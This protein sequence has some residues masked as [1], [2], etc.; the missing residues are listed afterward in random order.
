MA[1]LKQR[2]RKMKNDEIKKEETKKKWYVEVYD[3]DLEE[4]VEVDE[5]LPCQSKEDAMSEAKE[6]IK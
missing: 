6:R 4:Y 3:E 1:V 2:K 5:I